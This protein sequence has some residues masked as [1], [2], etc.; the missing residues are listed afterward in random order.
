MDNTILTIYS[1]K[2]SGS[3][4]LQK[5]SNSA[6]KKLKHSHEVVI[7]SESSDDDVVAV[8]NDDDDDDFKAPLQH[9]RQKTVHT[10]Q[11]KARSKHIPYGAG[12]KMKISRKM[13][14]FQRKVE[15]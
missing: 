4:H 1:T 9:K 2:K 13:M 3:R 15:Y 11:K 5:V 10:E 6:A 8:D 12:R 14:N 7:I